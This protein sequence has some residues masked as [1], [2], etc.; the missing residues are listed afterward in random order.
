[1]HIGWRRDNVRSERDFVHP[2]YNRFCNRHWYWDR[3]WN[4]DR[5]RN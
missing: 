4:R 3:D 5:Y 2:D 1:M